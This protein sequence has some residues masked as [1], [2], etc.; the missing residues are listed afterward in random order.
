MASAESSSE[1]EG[2]N[3][4]MSSTELGDPLYLRDSEITQLTNLAA[5]LS[6]DHDSLAKN[7]A[8]VRNYI[9]EASLNRAENKSESAVF[10]QTFRKL[11]D[12]EIILKS[13]RDAM[14]RVTLV[15]DNQISEPDKVFTDT[16]VNL[17]RNRDAKS[18]QEKY[19]HNEA[20]VSF[21][22][23]I[24]ETLY[25]DEAV[26]EPKNWFDQ[27]TGASKLLSEIYTELNNGNDDEEIFVARETRSLRCP[28]TLQLFVDPVTS[29]KCP[30][31]FSSQAIMSLLNRPR[32]RGNVECPVAG[33]NKILRK[34]DLKAD[35][36]LAKKVE[37]HM[38]KLAEEEQD[39]EVD[40]I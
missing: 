5:A 15:R 19:L 28:I 6:S 29:T 38:A 8:A 37:R 25:E 7:I 3:Y 10:D 2:G 23:N 32:S 27:E 4:G 33:C 11:I 34:T 24:W 39:E 14:E 18:D 17:R 40:E 30:H 35:P 26:P 22:N 21:R 36:A 9:T 12:L 1:D 20:Y 31:S 13:S 16:L